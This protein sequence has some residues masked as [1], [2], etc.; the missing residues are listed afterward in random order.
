LVVGCGDEGGQGPTGAQ[1]STGAEE[2]GSTGGGSDSAGTGT[3]SSSVDDSSSSDSNPSTT[4]SPGV[5]GDGTVDPGELCDDGNDEPG[6]GCSAE[7]APEQDLEIPYSEAPAAATH[8]SYSGN[9][10]GDRGSIVEQLDAGVRTLEYDVHADD[11]ASAGYRL[12]HDGP[13][14][15]VAH[16]SGNPDVDELGAWLQLV[17]SWSDDHPGH[18]PLTIYIDLKDEFDNAHPEAGNFIAFNALLETYLGARLYTPDDFRA[19]GGWP[20]VSQMRDRVVCVLT[21]DEDG[22]LDYRRDRGATPAIAINDAGQVVEVHQAQS[23]EDLWLWTGQIQADGRVRWLHHERYDTGNR[24]SV[25]LNNDGVIVEVHEDDDF[26]DDDLWYRVGQLQPG[27]G[28]QWAS[29]GGDR[30]PNEDEGVMP[31]VAFLS[32]DDDAVREVHQSQGDAQRWYWSATGVNLGAGTIDWQRPEGS[33]ETDDPFYPRTD[34]SFE[35][36]LYAVSIGID[37]PHETALLYEVGGTTRRIRYEQLAF[38]SARASSNDDLLEDGLE[39]F[40]DDARSGDG[41]AW[42]AERNAQG[43]LTRLW[44]FGVDHVSSQTPDNRVNF[45]ATD[46]PYEAWHEAYCEDAGCVR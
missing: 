20:W 6:D 1:G 23:Q 38:G 42:A 35:G 25:A 4:S 24:P 29:D 2:T 22:Q 27:G 28:V 15:E 11:F 31:S 3:T 41:R 13:G 12:G 44:E 21:G 46:H 19:D 7:C 32:L 39:F 17:A 8:N 14:D 37:G 18:S 34:A 26:A 43:K 9:E 10:A 5:C 40:A 16:G 45:G 33:G 30:F 36:S